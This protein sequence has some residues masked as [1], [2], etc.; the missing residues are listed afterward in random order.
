MTKYDVQI[1]ALTR[2]TIANL[3]DCIRAEQMN[4]DQSPLD[5]HAARRL[6]HYAEQLEKAARE[7]QALQD[8]ER[9]ASENAAS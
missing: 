8:A 5:R 7:I 3:L 6:T 1:R 2:S 9:D 4:V